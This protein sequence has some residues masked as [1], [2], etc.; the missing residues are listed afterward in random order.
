MKHVKIPS[1]WTGD[2]ALLMSSFLEELIRGIWRA[3]GE[4]MG[5]VLRRSRSPSASPEPKEN[6]V[7]DDDLP[8]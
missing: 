4:E 8:F 7:L 1:D 6:S 2:E 5:T 3:H